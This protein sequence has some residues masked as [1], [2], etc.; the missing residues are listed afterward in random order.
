MNKPDTDA[1]GLADHEMI[2]LRIELDSITEDYAEAHCFPAMRYFANKYFEIYPAIK[3]YNRLVRELDVAIN[4]EDGA[5]KQASLCDIVGQV[6]AMGLK[7]PAPV[8][9]GMPLD[10]APKDGTTIE[11]LY[12]GKWYSGHWYTH[13]SV[14]GWITTE[15]DCNDYEFEPIRWRKVRADL[16]QRGD[17]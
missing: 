9:D 5:A 12:E 1:I 17:A 7:Q 4:G 10:T 2:D 15:Y 6:K 13:P 8:A 16:T 3:D 14:S 11:L